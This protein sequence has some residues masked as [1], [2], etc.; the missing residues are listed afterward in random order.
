MYVFAILVIAAICI[1]IYVAWIPEDEL[2]RRAHPQHH[3]HDL[4]MISEHAGRGRPRISTMNPQ[5]I[6]DYQIRRDEVEQEYRGVPVKTRKAPEI[7][8]DGNVI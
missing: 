5:M 7:D 6:R 8:E 4:E 2:R 3:L 1:W